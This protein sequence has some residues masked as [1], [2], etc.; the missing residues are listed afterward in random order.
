M[1][2]ESVSTCQ[3]TTEFRII[4]FTT[5]ADKPTFVYVTARKVRYPELASVL[6]SA[7][8]L[9]GSLAMTV[10]S[11]LWRSCALSFS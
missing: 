1:Y 10:R 11:E 3:A 8:G 9:S 4:E 5:V 6:L 2:L 7:Q